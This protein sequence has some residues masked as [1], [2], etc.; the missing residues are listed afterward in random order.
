MGLEGKK[1]AAKD[2]ELSRTFGPGEASP[3]NLPMRAAAL[4]S[5]RL[6]VFTDIFGL[7]GRAFGSGKGCSDMGRFIDVVLSDALSLVEQARAA[8]G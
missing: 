1:I 4:A 3:E 8:A 7:M 5:G 2:L 6:G